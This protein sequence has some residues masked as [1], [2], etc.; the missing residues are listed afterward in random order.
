MIMESLRHP[1]NG[2]YAFRIPQES[3]S[4]TLGCLVHEVKDP[5]LAPV[6]Q[7]PGK[8]KTVSVLY[9]QY[10]QMLSG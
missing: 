4:R 8:V 9:S 10:T 3:I 7:E 6:I 1:G 2:N 5:C